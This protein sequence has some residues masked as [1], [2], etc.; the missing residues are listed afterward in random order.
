MG[1]NEIAEWVKDNR[2][3][4]SL[5]Y[6]IWGDRIWNTEVSEDTPDLTWS[7]WRPVDDGDN[8]GITENH[9]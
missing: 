4:L 9:W 2:D 7:N 5:R 8:V 1:G 3:E 6:V